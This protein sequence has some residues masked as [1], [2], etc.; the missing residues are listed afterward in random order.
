MYMGPT[1]RVF[2]EDEK[3]ALLQQIDAEIDKVIKSYLPEIS[4]IAK[5]IYINV[6]NAAQS[7]WTS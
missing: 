4:I 6:A 7:D 2:F 1:L 5:E 3:A